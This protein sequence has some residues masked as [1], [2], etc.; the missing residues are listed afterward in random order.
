MD[1]PSTNAKDG[2]TPS[3]EPE[4][5]NSASKPATGS[6]YSDEFIHKYLSATGK[7][8]NQ[9]IKTAL[10]RLDAINA[11]TGH[12]D[13]DEPFIVPGASQSVR[14]N[15]LYAQDLRLMSHTRKAWSLLHA[16]GSVTTE[17]IHSVRVPENPTSHTGSFEM[18]AKMSTVREFLST[19]AIRVTDDYGYDEDSVHGVDW[20]SSFSNV[21]GNVKGI[22][23]PMLVMGMTGHWEY[24]ASETVYELAKS[25]DK[26]LVFVEGASHTYD[27][28]H[29]CEKFPGQFGDTLKTTYDY[30]DKWLSQNGRFLVASKR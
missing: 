22:T 7:R 10:D 21:P 2:K 16:D 14:N 8:N 18:G 20:S 27:T 11:G 26:T 12:Y 17:A 1:P 29:Q 23:V 9:L 3:S 28:C 25:S 30:A 15:K 4:M 5:S 13:D 19:Y 24:L 6:T